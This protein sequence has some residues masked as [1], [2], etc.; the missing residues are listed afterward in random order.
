MIPRYRLVVPEGSYEAD[1]L[2]GLLWEI[3]SHRLWHFF[4]GDG[5][6]D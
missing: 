2:V 3:V 5:W 4:Q 1:S 6:I